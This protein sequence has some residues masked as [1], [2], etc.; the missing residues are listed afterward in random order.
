MREL[1][2]SSAEAHERIGALIAGTEVQLAIFFGPEMAKAYA[3]CAQQNPIMA[4]LHCPDFAS[5]SNALA[6]R[7]YP[8]DRIL[9]K[10]SRGMALER[11]IPVL[12][13]LFPAVA[14]E[15]NRA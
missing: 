2:D 13:S 6:G 9:L 14:K 5:L 7:I 12:D 1:G 11:I 10:A 8:K 15:L 4:A 3:V